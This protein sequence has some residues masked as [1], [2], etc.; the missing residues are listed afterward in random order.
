M[1]TDFF[2]EFAQLRGV[3]FCFSF[4]FPFFGHFNSPHFLWLVLFFFLSNDLRVH[5]CSCRLFRCKNVCVC[6]RACV[7]PTFVFEKVEDTRMQWKE[8]FLLYH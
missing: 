7:V 3:M 4:C 8:V 6:P 2:I 1:T 5:K